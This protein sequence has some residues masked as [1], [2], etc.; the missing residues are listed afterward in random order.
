MEGYPK[1]LA[2]GIMLP[3]DDFPPRRI[4]LIEDETCFIGY[5]R[6]VDDKICEGY[7]LLLK[8]STMDVAALRWCKVAFPPK[9]NENV[10][11]LYKEIYHIIQDDRRMNYTGEYM[12]IIRNKYKKDTCIV[13]LSDPLNP[14]TDD[15]KEAVKYY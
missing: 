5:A 2:I 4:Y 10:D 11:E 6:G 13:N 3:F 8:I 15:E 12:G 14:V 7:P 1:L 9:G